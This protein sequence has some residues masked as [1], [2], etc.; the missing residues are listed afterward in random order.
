MDALAASL[1]RSPELFPHAWDLQSDAVTL[2]R[3]TQARLRQG[4]LP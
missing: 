1:E 2:V 3:L 4:Q